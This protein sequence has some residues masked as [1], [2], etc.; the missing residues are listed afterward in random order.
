MSTDAAKTALLDALLSLQTRAEADAFLSDLCTPAELRAFAERWQVARLLDG[1]DKTYREIAV[2]ASA[3]PTTS[4]WEPDRITIAATY[5]D[6]TRAVSAIDSPRESWRA[7]PVSTIGWPPSSWTPASKETLVR[8]DGFSKISAAPRPSRGR[9]S[10][11][12]GRCARSRIRRTS[13]TDSAE[14]SRK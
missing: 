5:R 4:G 9:P 3:S 1:G 14:M 10:D 12:I 8:V 7:S 2:E 6:M 11:A 13:S